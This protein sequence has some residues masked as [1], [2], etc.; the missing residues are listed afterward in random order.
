MAKRT[1]DLHPLIR[2]V[3]MISESSDDF[4]VTEPPSRV[5]RIFGHSAFYRQ[6]IDVDGYPVVASENVNPYALKEAAWLIWHLTRH[7]PDV[8]QAMVREE[9]GFIVIAYQEM[10]TQIPEYS[11]FV[12]GFYWDVRARGLGTLKSSCGEENLLNYPDDPYNGESIAIHEFSHSMHLDGLN[13]LNPDFDVRLE[14]AY[15]AAMAN[16]LWRGTYASVNRL[17]YWAEGVQ[18]WFNAEHEG[19]SFPAST[20]AE[21]KDYDPELA[22][23]LV[24]VFGDADW[25]YT[26]PEVRTHLPHLKGFDPSESPM[27][28]WPQELLACYWELFE[29]NGFGGDK[30]VNLAPIRPSQLSSLRSPHGEKDATEIIFINQ[31]GVGITSYWVDPNGTKTRYGHLASPHVLYTSVDH[32]WLVEDIDGN[33][34]AVF[35]ATEETGRAYIGPSSMEKVSGDDQRAPAGAQLPRPFEV[36]VLDQIGITAVGVTVSFN[37]TEGEGTLSIVDIATDGDGQAAT[38]LTLGSQ[39]GA[40]TVDVITAG[41][42]PV[43]FSAV[44][45]VV[46][47]SL[48]GVSGFE[49]EGPPGTTLA[50]PFV[51]SVRDQNGNP[52]NG[53]AVTFSFTTGEGTLSEYSD[54]TGVDGHASTTLT[55][56]NE[57]GMVVVVATVKDLDPVTF[58]AVAKATS[59]FDSDGIVGFADFLLFAGAYG[60]SNDDAEFEARFDL[61]GN[62]NIGFG[63]FLIFAGRFGNEV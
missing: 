61:D 24:E 63:D 28:E 2:D 37:V 60:L 26:V 46:A 1:T 3:S 19:P 21:L 10:L 52:F 30:W 23:L 5:R 38:T 58:T 6:W 56:G 53:M 50:E 41:L 39:P 11:E 48:Q 32:I 57:L 14:S 7:R 31:G 44:G 49:Q 9:A 35:Q 13:A 36:S 12:P 51:V 43:T 8:L 25:R 62:G 40:N 20:R 22:K 33:G 17:E 27:F 16:G 55:F 34:L 29:W 4:P 54:T 18:S 45:F 42:Q 59:D 15:R 47:R